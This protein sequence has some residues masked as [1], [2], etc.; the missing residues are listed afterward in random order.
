RW[1]I[2]ERDDAR[3]NLPGFQNRTV[4]GHSARKKVGGE[5]GRRA[6][7]SLKLLPE[8]Q[9]LRAVTFQVPYAT[10]FSVTIP[11]LRQYSPL[12]IG[13]SFSE[14]P[15]PHPI[16]RHRQVFLLKGGTAGMKEMNVRDLAPGQ[17]LARPVLGRK[18]LVMLEADTVLTERYITKLKELGIAK[19]YIKDRRDEAARKK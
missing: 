8:T 5:M 11:E 2:R 4:D 3:Q 18:G 10:I 19:V 7:L 17:V 6:V 1:G 12:F 13:F 14:I 9:V 16:S 15:I